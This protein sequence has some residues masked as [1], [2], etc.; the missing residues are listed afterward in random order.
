[1]DRLDAMTAFCAVAE[2]RSFSGAAR[3]LRRSPPVIT[4]LVAALEEQLGVPL[5]QRTTRSVT[6]TAAGSRYLERARRILGEVDDAERAARAE[7]SEPA[8][9]LVITAPTAFGRLAVAPLVSEF[10][11]RHPQVTGE[12]VMID[13]MVQLVDEGVD[14]AVRIGVLRDSSL[15]VRAVGSA[16]RVVVA[17]PEYLAASRRPR[18]PADLKGH[19]LIQ[20]TSIASLPEW[21]FVRDGVEAAVGIA[22]RYVTNSADAAVEHAIRGGGLA[23]VLSYHVKDAVRSGALEVLLVRHEPP[24]LPIQVVWAGTRFVSASVRAFVDWTVNTRDWD[25]TDL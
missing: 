15:R 11:T 5:L 18:S 3:R 8:G 24:P 16:R 14:V 23:M 7:R 9:R 22:P 17:S 10:L 19:A 4:R 20:F 12:L 1:M 2:L 6:L 13:R 25:Y 21:R